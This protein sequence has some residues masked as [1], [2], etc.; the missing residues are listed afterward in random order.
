MEFTLDE[1]FEKILFLDSVPDRTI[2]VI[3]EE[4]E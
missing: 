3:E 1:V 2:R 4:E